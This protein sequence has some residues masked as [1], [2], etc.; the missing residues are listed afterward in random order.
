MSKLSSAFNVPGC[1][2]LFLG[3][4]HTVIE[5]S[6]QTE[7]LPFR[8]WPCPSCI[9][10]YL[11]S[12]CFFLFISWVP[13]WASLPVSRHS[14]TLLSRLRVQGCSCWCEGV[15]TSSMRVTSSLLLLSSL[16]HPAD[17]TKS[18]SPFQIANS[19]VLP[20]YESCSIRPLT[21]QP[22]HRSICIGTA[23]IS[24]LHYEDILLLAFLLL[25]ACL[26]SIHLYFYK[27]KNWPHPLPG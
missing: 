3:L 8:C 4:F 20:S 19:M 16:D 6:R 7:F 2:P 23:L 15:L 5:F 10:Y 11:F 21:S 18:S 1:I 12:C 24:R 17:S 26:S 14:E 25:Q 22:H 13:G 27:C 9:I